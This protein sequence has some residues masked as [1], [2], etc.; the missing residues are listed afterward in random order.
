MID[1][2]PTTF[3]TDESKLMATLANYVSIISRFAQSVNLDRD[4]DQASSLSGYIVTDRTL[5]V[6]GRVAETAAIGKSGGAWSLTGPYGSGKSSLAI[7]LDA[8]FGPSSKT[9]D[10]AL[11]LL[12]EASPSVRKLIQES[13]YRYRTNTRGFHRGLV[14]AC[15][16]PLCLTLLRAL[17]IAVIRSYGKIPPISKFQAAKL[18]RQ[19]LKDAEND[20]PTTAPSPTAVIEIA[21]CLAK[22]A[23]LLLVIDE[24][25][26]NLE[27][28]RD[29]NNTDPYLLQQLAEA[30]QGSGLPIFI[31]TLQHQ[32][33]EDY[34]VGTND[35][36][37]REW[38][39]VQGRFEDIAY[40]ESTAQSRKLIGSVFDIG[41]S[42]L[43][44]RIARW[45]NDRYRELQTLGE[46]E[47]ADPDTIASCYPLHPLTALVLPELCNRFGQHERTMFSF[48]TSAD[49][50]SAVAFITNTPLPRG[51]NLPSIGLEAIYDFFVS[52]GTLANISNCQSSRWIEIA[53]RLR[54]VYALSREQIELAKSIAV[55]NLISTSGTIRASR[56]ILALT[57]NDVRNNLKNLESASIVTYRDYVDEYRVWQGTDVDINQLLEFA[58]QRV[59][60]QSLVEILKVIDS[61]TPVVAA[62]HSAQQETLRVFTRRYTDGNEIIEPL[63]PFSPF[64]GEVLLVVGTKVPRLKQWN[65]SHKPV[66]A[67]VPETIDVID[68][69]ARETVAIHAVLDEPVVTNDWVAQCELRERLAHKQSVLEKVFHTTF[70]AN[71]T[72]WTLLDSKDGIVLPIGRGSA[73]L[74]TAADKAYPS[75][76]MIRNEM[77]NRTTL[78]TQGAK[79]R[80]MVLQAMI[81]NGSN[82]DLGFAGYGPEVAIYSAVLKQ[83]G[84]HGRDRRNDFMVFRKPTEKNLFPVWDAIEDEFRRARFSRVN[85]SNI[86]ATLL[87]PP[88]GMKAGVVPIFVTAALL[89]FRNEV[90]IYEHGTFKPLLTADLSERMVKNPSHFDIKHF[91]NNTGARRQV[92]DALVECFN[93]KP[94]FRKHRVANVLTVVGYL[95]TTIRKLDNYTIQ[96]CNLCPD[97]IKLRDTILSAVEPDKLL[98]E[99]LPDAIGLQQI[100][101]STKIY[102]STRKY[103]KRVKSALEELVGC[104]DQLLTELFDFILEICI[105]SD[106][107]SITGQAAALKNEVLNPQIK[108]LVGI[109]ANNYFNNDDWANAVATIVAKKAPAE[110]TDEDLLVFRSEFSQQANTFRRLV[111]LHAEHRTHGDGPFNSLRVA[112]TKSDGSEFVDLVGIDENFRYEA[113]KL[114][115]SSL[116][117]LTKTT[118]YSVRRAHSNLL[119]LLCEQLMLESGD[120]LGKNLVEFKNKE[121]KNG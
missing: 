30:G 94:S 88:I 97:T 105:E 33:F 85:V 76:P 109:L 75:T 87:A 48:L 65:D 16:E 117:K 14:T 92:I 121:A 53:I 114:L 90:A 86:F 43:K 40:V 108:T 28:I 20:D 100:P 91:A 18:L 35:S 69:V 120:D 7:L 19:A 102:L 27:A 95:V 22:D 67:V 81:E 74:S 41:N 54:D 58:Y 46:N 71:T 119:A 10:K 51:R 25:G 60:K 21:R 82:S 49:P 106:R 113:T 56:K 23:P 64:D 36:Q 80:R 62:R 83:T 31:L 12:D 79:A 77:V 96:T 8:M 99:S 50:A 66:V 72:K 52:N 15:R 103:A 89:A 45:A 32:S 118:G 38:S 110:W 101:A 39:K 112:I 4:C 61:P 2:L 17:N 3:T 116:E 1:W 5:S 93:L 11:K 13:H 70:G 44:A 34:F 63:D 59:Q 84:I 37:R 107:I 24:F 55:L 42:E 68:R 57:N 115:N 73:A 47:L 111:A 9:R 6:V 29:D 104:Y 78:S 26:K 98:F